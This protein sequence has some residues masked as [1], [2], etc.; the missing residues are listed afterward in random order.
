[1]TVPPGY[2]RVRSHIRRN[3]GPRTGARKMSGWT[4]AGL[5]A[6]VWLWAHFF[7]FGDSGTTTPPAPAVTAPA[8][9]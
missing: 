6:L 1:M 2:H 5:C 8:A 7:G 3:P 4:I 9:R